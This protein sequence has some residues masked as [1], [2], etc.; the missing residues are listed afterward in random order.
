MTAATNP[1]APR[2]P[3]RGISDHLYACLVHAYPAELRDEFGDE[4]VGM[5]HA[6]RQAA[7]RNPLRRA[8]LWVLAIVDILVHATG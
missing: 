1:A 5:F 3:R 6:Q 4:M 8:R 7:G 2:H